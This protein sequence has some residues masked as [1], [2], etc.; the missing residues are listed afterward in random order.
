[1]A[2]DDDFPRGVLLSESTAGANASVTFPATP[3]IT[4]VLTS[5]AASGGS[6]YAGTFSAA[7]QVGAVVLADTNG[8]AANA[9][10]ATFDIDWDGQYSPVAVG[11]ALTVTVTQTGSLNVNL[12]ASAYPV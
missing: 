8:D 6:G 4:W 12:I 7:L 11:G 1:M 10:E 2:A 3:G 5:A 9:G